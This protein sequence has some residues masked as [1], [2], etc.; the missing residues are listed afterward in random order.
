MYAA[1]RPWQCACGTDAVCQMKVPL[2][3]WLCGLWFAFR[4]LPLA[5]LKLLMS[6]T[7][8]LCRQRWNGYVWWPRVVRSG[9]S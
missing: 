4:C 9:A 5:S 7:L 1:N 3:D 8:C 2:T 6:S